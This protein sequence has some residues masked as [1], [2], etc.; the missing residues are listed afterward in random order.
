MN[1]NSHILKLS[2]K[3]ELPHEIE[4][5]FNYHVSLAGSIN[6]I[7][8]HDNEDGTWN[9][10]YTFKPIT[11]ELLDPK[12]KSLKLKDP[13]KNSQKIRNMLWKHYFNEGVAEDFDSLYD[14]FTQEV[15][16]QTPQLMREAL[17]RLN[18]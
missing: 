6:K 12:G 4:E 1:I 10:V 13:R 16:M 2:G 15:M 9:K 3:S 5:G 18:K 8:F 7:E 11:V 17:N 14:A